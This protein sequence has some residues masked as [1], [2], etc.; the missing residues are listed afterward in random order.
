MISFE[1]SENKVLVNV[2]HGIFFNDQYFQLD[3]NQ[4]HPYQAELLYRQLNKTLREK[5][6]SIRREEYEKGW[7][8]AKAKRAKQTW[9]SGKF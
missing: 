6:E 3:I 4:G 2:Q 7:K 9:F 8:D 5:L 1:R